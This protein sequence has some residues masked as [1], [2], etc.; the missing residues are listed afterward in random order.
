ML[1]VGHEKFLGPVTVNPS[2]SADRAVVMRTWSLFQRYGRKEEKYGERFSFTGYTSTGNLF[3]AWLH[4]AGLSIAVATI[5]LLPPLR[6]LIALLAPR[7]GPGPVVHEDEKWSVEWKAVAEADLK[8]GGAEATA[9]GVMHVAVDVFTC[10]AM[11]AAEVALTLVDELGSR[12]DVDD[13]ASLAMRLGGG[14]LTP[15]SLGSRYI[16]RLQRAGFQIRV[17]WHED[18]ETGA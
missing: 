5:L 17:G 12:A 7:M 13:R 1:L 4:F 9:V 14:V 15:A 10:C 16:E 2:A 8:D 6:W 3:A 11:L 18:E